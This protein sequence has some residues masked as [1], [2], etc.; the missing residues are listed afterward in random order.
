MNGSQKQQIL[1]DKQEIT[2]VMY[3]FAR[4]LDR[5]DGEL[6]KACY[7]EDAIEEDQDPI[8]PDLFSRAKKE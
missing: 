7:W 5:M 4:A 8:F 3:R 2:E 1:W 6:M